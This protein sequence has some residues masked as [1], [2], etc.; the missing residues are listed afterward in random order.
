M[1]TIEQ[2]DRLPA[3]EIDPFSR[4]LSGLIPGIALIAVVSVAMVPFRDRLG[5]GS[6]AILLLIPV[7]LAT[8]GGVWVALA[9]AVLGATTLNYFFTTPYDTFRIESAEG[10]TAFA[11]Y[12]VVAVLVAVALS[13]RREAERL[14]GRRD[15]DARFVL[16]ATT[17]FADSSSD[18]E[19]SISA[20]LAGLLFAAH[21][22]GVELRAGDLSD[23]AGEPIAAAARVE[24][25]GGLLA[26]DPGVEPLSG[27]RLRL[28][29]ELAA[30]FSLALVAHANA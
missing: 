10:I 14:A 24:F 8:I 11:S 19:D 28:V 25:G 27:D 17:Q 6:P 30:V 3:P 29:E 20:A 26:V 1:A 13:R 16:G 15:R 22:R 4:A 9:V 2:H 23:S 21:L 18:I 12:I 5:P 7:L